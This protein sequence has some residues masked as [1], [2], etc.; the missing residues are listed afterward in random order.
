MGRLQEMVEAVDKKE[1][2]CFLYLAGRGGG[3]Y[4]RGLEVPLAIFANDNR[5]KRDAVP[6]C[7]RLHQ[8][9]ALNQR[10]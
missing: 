3:K 9:K 7:Q 5:E 4:F 8:K 6:K 1:M 10:S 2:I